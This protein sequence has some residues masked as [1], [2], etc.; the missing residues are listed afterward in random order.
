MKKKTILMIVFLL[1][2]VTVV[3]YLSLL[4]D[5]EG[6]IVKKCLHYNGQW[7]AEEKTCARAEGLF[8]LT[9][10]HSLIRDKKTWCDDLGGEVIDYDH[11][12]LDETEDPNCYLGIISACKFE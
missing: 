1:V 8:F 7:I 6:R 10:D 9:E 2:I 11:C 4:R 12:P 5:K 3:V